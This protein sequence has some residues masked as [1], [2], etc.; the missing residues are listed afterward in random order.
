MDKRI[1]V[2]ENFYLDEFV[3]PHTYFNAL[4]S[5][6]G[7]LSEILFPIAQKLRDL[8]GKPISINNWWKYYENSSNLTNQQIIS[9]IEY[10]NHHG[11]VNIWSGYRSSRC[12]VGARKSA[13]RYGLAIDPKGNEKK[14]FKIVKDN[15]EEF[16][17]L[18]LR[19]LE[20]ISITPGWLHMDGALLNTKPNSIRVVDRTSCTETI[21]IA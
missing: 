21:F 9:D 1:I 3:D 13:H 6:I 19:R 17:N 11:K 2:S 20:D 14:F 16:Y 5:G 8:Y 4:N 10:L 12:H 15:R 7:L 18:G